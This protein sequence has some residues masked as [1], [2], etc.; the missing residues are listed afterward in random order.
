[1][2]AHHLYRCRLLSPLPL[3]VQGHYAVYVRKLITSIMMKVPYIKARKYICS[4]I[5]YIAYRDAM[6][7]IQHALS[8]DY[9]LS[10]KYG[11]LIKMVYQLTKGSKHILLQ[12]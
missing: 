8:I 9:I 6:F 1:M 2:A 3:P 10:Y 4:F 12:L 5:P 7:L 11:N